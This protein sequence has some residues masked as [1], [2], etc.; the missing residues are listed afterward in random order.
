MGGMPKEYVT[1]VMAYLKELMRRDPAVS[2]RKMP[3]L[4]FLPGIR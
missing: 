3:S 2:Y 1:N 4:F